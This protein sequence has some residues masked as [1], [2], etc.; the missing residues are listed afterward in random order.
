MRNC[1]KYNILILTLLLLLTTCLIS[2]KNFN[3]GAEFNLSIEN[4]YCLHGEIIWV[5]A[6][7]INKMSTAIVLTGDFEEDNGFKIMIKNDKGQELVRK[8][9]ILCK[10]FE[11]EDTT[12][13]LQP[14][15]TLRTFFNL[16]WF[17]I[18]SKFITVESSYNSINSNELKIDI[19]EP[20]SID[21]E[22]KNL[23]NEFNQNYSA[24]DTGNYYKD[25]VLQ[26]V[27]NNYTQSR[28]VP[29]A[30]YLLL[31]CFYFRHDINS[32][33]STLEKY[34][35]KYADSP[36]S[37]FIISN[38]YAFLRVSFL[39]IPDK[40]MRKIAASKL[41]ELERIYPTNRILKYMIEQFISNI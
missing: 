17:P 16:S 1:A 3:Q 10:M 36:Y 34:L 30:Y 4:E 20:E 19:K 39:A 13:Y 40:I 41:R 28:F 35:N 8:G 26:K 15:D 14:N 32:Y 33:I 2:C 7:F 12:F 23:I 22:A 27:I 9:I 21:K 37:N 5:K 25:K 18:D 11:F 31:T 24:V 29:E 38:Y 6:E